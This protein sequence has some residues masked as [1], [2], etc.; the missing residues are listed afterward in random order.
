M[1]TLYSH[2]SSWVFDCPKIDANSYCCYLKSLTVLDIQK[3]SSQPCSLE[4]ACFVAFSAWQ[5]IME[6]TDQLRRDAH[7]HI[8]SA[9]QLQDLLPWLQCI[10]LDMIKDTIKSHIQTDDN[11]R[12]SYYRSMPITSVL[13]E[14]ICRK[15]VFCANNKDQRIVSKQFHEFSM[16]DGVNRECI[17]LRDCDEC[18]CTV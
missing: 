13:N 15:I 10:P 1:E 18:D 11:L 16:M 6:P 17:P 14:N 2:L 8:D 3:T 12:R 4:Q 7:H 9:N 5:R